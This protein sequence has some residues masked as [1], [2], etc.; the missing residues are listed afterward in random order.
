MKKIFTFSLLLILTIPSMV[1]AQRWKR[2]RYEFSLGLGV[3]NFLGEL[4]GAN[5]I[6]THYFRDLEFSQTRLAAALGLRYKLSNYFAVKTDLTYGRVSGDDKLTTEKFRHTRNINFYAD[7][8]EWNLNFEGAFQQEQIGHRYRLKKVRGL[9]G[10][11]L[12]TYLFAGVGVFYF[13]P[14]AEFQGQ[15][16]NLRDYHTEGQG[17]VPTRKNYS[18]FQLCIPLGIGFKYTIDRQWGLGLEF[19]IR[20]TFTDYIDDVST[21]YI[22]L[23]QYQ[24]GQ[25]YDV[26]Q[27]LANPSDRNDPA[28]AGIT[29]PGQQRGDPRYK[30]SYMF[31]IFS[32]NYKIK[33]GRNNLPRF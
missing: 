22:D 12:Y 32:V 18:T 20:K 30:D 17:Y 10:Y 3:S 15:T 8:Y 14:K 7:I 26:G 23:S 5:Q 16:Y 2:Q 21:T 19:G 11:E 29:A 24:T 31:A 1:N 33:T 4:G 6:G 25:Q 13:N 9:K 28:A 27:F